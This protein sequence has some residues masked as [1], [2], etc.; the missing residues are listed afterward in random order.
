MPVL[1]AVTVWIA[2]VW[3]AILGPR[4]VYDVTSS[5]VNI[6]SLTGHSTQGYITEVF[7]HEKRYRVRY[8]H[9]FIRDR[10]YYVYKVFCQVRGNAPDDLMKVFTKECVF[11]T[12]ILD[13][14]SNKARKAAAIE[15]YLDVVLSELERDKKSSKNSL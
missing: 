5:T 13:W 2:G 9:W 8:A 11:P 6:E 15:A 3:E 12:L 14:S 10:Y 7:C 4:T 1:K